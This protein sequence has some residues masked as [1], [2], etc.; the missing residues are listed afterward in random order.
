MWPATSPRTNKIKTTT[1]L[2]RFRIQL[3]FIYSICQTLYSWP[4][5]GITTGLSDGGEPQAGSTCGLAGLQHIARASLEVGQGQVSKLY[6]KIANIKKDFVHKSS[7]D[8]SKNHAVVFVE[9]LSIRN[10]SKSGRGSQENHG[11]NV[12]QKSGLNRETRRIGILSLQGRQDLKFVFG[13]SPPCL[14]DERFTTLVTR[15]RDDY[16]AIK[17]SRS[18]FVAVAAGL[19]TAL[20]V[21]SRIR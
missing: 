11:T 13:R 2:V 18:W 14:S 1:R 8:L 15:G 20:I 4:E 21:I 17:E 7:N 5:R 6:N 12:K 3:K 19:E 9:D 10:M 16:A